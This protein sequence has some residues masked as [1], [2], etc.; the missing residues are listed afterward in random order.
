MRTNMI[1]YL[2]IILVSITGFFIFFNRQSPRTNEVAILLIIYA[3][4]LL[5]FYLSDINKR[6]AENY[7]SEKRSTYSSYVAY[8]IKDS[9]IKEI[10]LMRYYA[11]TAGTTVYSE[12]LPAFLLRVSHNPSHTLDKTK[13][14]KHNMYPHLLRDYMELKVINILVWSSR[15]YQQPEPHA[16]AIRFATNVSV[17]QDIKSVIKSTKRISLE[18]LSAKLKD[19]QLYQS[20]L[21]DDKLTPWL[22][23]QWK[24]GLAIP[25]NTEA[26]LIVEHPSD[27]E[28]KIVLTFHKRGLPFFSDSLIINVSVNDDAE[29]GIHFGAW[30]TAYNNPENFGTFMDYIVTEPNLTVKTEFSSFT[31]SNPSHVLH[32]KWCDYLYEGLKFKLDFA[33]DYKY[34]DRRMIQSIF[35]SSRVM[36]HRL[37]EIEKKLK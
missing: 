11:T 1:L 6:K 3:V 29:E 8:S 7:I 36:K 14:F 20:F 37:D 23:A 30:L 32:Q 18:E 15:S 13:P 17:D 26:S 33:E 24:D 16:S 4:T 21:L 10:P 12:S 22:V 28:S 9:H 27:K 34:I 2:S 35:E 19:N 5:S 31:L 25:Q